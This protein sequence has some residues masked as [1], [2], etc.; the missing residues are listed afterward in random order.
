MEREGE[1]GRG[2]EVGREGERQKERKR[3]GEDGLLK[4][5]SSSP[6]THLLQHLPILLTLFYQ[7]L[8][9]YSNI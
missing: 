8:T 2:A 3:E 1:R 9:K 5:Q 4:H 6:V 7:L